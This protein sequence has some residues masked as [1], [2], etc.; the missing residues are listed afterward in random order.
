MPLSSFL[1]GV[2][3]LTRDETENFP[4][5]FPKPQIDS[6]IFKQKTMFVVGGITKPFT[7]NKYKSLFNLS[8]AKT[9]LPPSCGPHFALAMTRNPALSSNP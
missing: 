1:N 5:I 2:L 9:Q 4:P 6:H 8:S 7:P 3:L